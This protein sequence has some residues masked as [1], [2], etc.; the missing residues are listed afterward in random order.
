MLSIHICCRSGLS[1]LS[2]IAVLRG[3]MSFLNVSHL[4]LSA[5]VEAI[6]TVMTS[7]F[8]LTVPFG[9][10]I[11]LSMILCGANATPSIPIAL[12]ATITGINTAVLRAM[13]EFCLGNNLNVAGRQYVFLLLFFESKR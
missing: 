4:S 5:A 9:R 10:V 1:Y 12:A 8:I 13:L 6:S 2:N 7:S 11:L 3:N